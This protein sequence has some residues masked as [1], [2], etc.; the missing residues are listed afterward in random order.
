[1]SDTKELLDRAHNNLCRQRDD[2]LRKGDKAL[3]QNYCNQIAGFMIC[4]HF[5]P[6]Q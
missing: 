3:Y 1:M 5:L 4:R 6:K 2:A